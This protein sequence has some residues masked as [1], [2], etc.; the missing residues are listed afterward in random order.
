MSISRR[1]ALKTLGLI[2]PAMKALDS[3]AARPSEPFGTA[4]SFGQYEIPEWFKDAKFGIWAHWGPQSAIEAGDWYARRM[5]IE[6]EEQYKYHL[7]HYGHPSKFGYKDTIPNWKAEKFDPDYLLGLYKKAGAK[8][9]MSMGAHHD[10]FDLWDSKYNKWNS[11]NMGPKIDVVG[12]FKK[13]A[14]NHGLKFGV[15]D[16]LWISPKWFSVSKGSDK[17]GKYAGVPYDGT[18]PQFADLYGDSV[19]IFNEL[20]WNEDGISEAWKKRW[21]L[22]VKDLVD[23]YEPDMI[24]CDGHLPFGEVGTEFLDHFHSQNAK[25]NGGKVQSVYTSKRVEDTTLGA[26][27][28]DLERGVVDGIWPTA[29]QTDTCIGDWH[30]NKARIGNYKSPKTVIDMLVDVVSRNGNLMLSIPLPNSG[31]PDSDELRILD[32]ITKWMA[33]NSEGIYATRPW[34]IYG[35]G[36]STLKAADN[37]M[38]NE[39]KRKDLSHEDFR[40]TTKQGSLYCFMMGW[41]E[42]GDTTIGALS[43]H[44]T[45][46]GRIDQ[47]Q[48]VGY[49][50][51]SFNR[52]FEGLKITLPAKMPGEYACVFKISGVGLV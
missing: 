25:R 15:S 27:V 19:K 44:S 18:N 13:A 38:F 20:P 1:K 29:Y 5:Y 50:P 47:V 24:Y 33:I 42:K 52:T 46:V 31:M 34:K 21:L 16:H 8:Y 45:Q 41:P 37:S 7:Q 32:A 39:S 2:L 6:G 30:Y 36:P 43:T 4:E 11:V 3:L 48:L 14:A 35:S 9:F 17:T 12:M 49:G 28:Y 40:F 23:R 10:N 26:C 51:V 22:R